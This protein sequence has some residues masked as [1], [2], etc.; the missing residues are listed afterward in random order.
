MCLPHNIIKSYMR[1]AVP[2]NNSRHAVIAV[3]SFIHFFAIFL[4]ILTF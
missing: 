2:I 4:N 1:S 3:Q